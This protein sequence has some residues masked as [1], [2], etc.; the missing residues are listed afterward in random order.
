MQLQATKL[1][2]TI[3]MARIVLSVAILTCLLAGLSSFLPAPSVNLAQFHVSYQ[4][5]AVS[6]IASWT[7]E[8]WRIIVDP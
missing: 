4:L 3:D 1:Q 6:S 7:Y 8:H 2:Q 5:Q